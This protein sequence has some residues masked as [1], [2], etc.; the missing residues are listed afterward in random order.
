[1]FKKSI[2]ALCLLVSFSSL[3]AS[4]DDFNESLLRDRIVAAYKAADYM[5]VLLNKYPPLSATYYDRYLNEIA[6]AEK[7]ENKLTKLLESK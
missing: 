3:S 4:H 7:L 2:F 1:M 5:L 6:R